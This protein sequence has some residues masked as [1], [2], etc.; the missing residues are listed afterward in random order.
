MESNLHQ[1]AL[2]L[3]SRLDSLDVK[4]DFCIKHSVFLHKAPLPSKWRRNDSAVGEGLRKLKSLVKSEKRF[5]ARL[6][7]NST[8]PSHVNCSNVPYLESLFALIQT[9]SELTS[10][11]KTFP[12][13]ANLMPVL[14]NGRSERIRVDVVCE[15]GLKWIKVKARNLRSVENDLREIE[16]ENEAFGSSD[17]DRESINI[18]NEDLMKLD[19]FRTAKRL[20]LAAEQN[21]IH[22]QA[23]V[24]VI[25]FVGN[26]R[27]E[28]DE[29]IVTL[30]EGIGVEVEIGED[31][32]WRNSVL[33]Q[34]DDLMLNIPEEMERD[35]E[36]STPIDFHNAPIISSTLNLD[37]TTLLALV[38]EICHDLETMPDEAFSVGPLR[39]QKEQEVE[40]PLLPDLLDLLNSRN[41]VCTH[42]AAEKFLSI[43][44]TVGGPSERARAVKILGDGIIKAFEFD[45]EPFSAATVKVLGN[46]PHI[47]VIP[48]DPHESFKTLVNPRF[49]PHH[50]IIFGTSYKLKITTITANAWICTAMGDVGS[51][52]SIAVHQPRSLVEQR[53]VRVINGQDPCTGGA[54]RRR[55]LE[56]KKRAQEEDA[57][58]VAGAAELSI[59]DGIDA[60]PDMS[61]W[62]M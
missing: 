38:S 14:K 26:R 23:P 18:E 12:Y 53:K 5:F 1:Q 42:T 2:V 34:Y 24:V 48:D 40:T 17:E 37:V 61:L 44:S 46:L 19:I 10:C 56:R 43:L 54:R 21:M 7:V 41:C 15:R 8:K 33:R 50:F 13:N 62:A 32:E 52:I 35:A 59:T 25:R 31:S 9:S 58:I 49:A 22:Y 47:T 55:E 4:L 57:G 3:A 45:F 20:M 27:D 51:D 30:L 11:L 60:E 6:D 39:L 36:L 28:V 29:R 16:I